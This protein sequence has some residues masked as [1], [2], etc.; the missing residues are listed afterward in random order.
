MPSL[1]SSHIN[2]YPLFQN[3][4]TLKSSSF[5]TA[6][7]CHFVATQ[8]MMTK[9][10]VLLTGVI[11]K[12]KKTQW[13]WELSWALPGRAQPSS[14][15]QGWDRQASCWATNLWKG[16]GDTWR[17]TAC[18]CHLYTGPKNTCPAQRSSPKPRGV[19]DFIT[20]RSSTCIYKNSCLLCKYSLSWCNKHLHSSRKYVYL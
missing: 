11:R 5:S 10:T 1:L 4:D 16:Q 6:L 20:C 15:S 8:I 13:Q 9:S 12:Q 19:T 7:L 14:M 18:Q 3:T 2:L 17:L